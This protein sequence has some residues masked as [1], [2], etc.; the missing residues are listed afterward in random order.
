MWHVC[1][2]NTFDTVS[3]I[4][5]LAR[6][7]NKYMDKLELHAFWDRVSLMEMSALL[8]RNKQEL[9]IEKEKWK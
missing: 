1:E 2:I 3:I 7:F 8:L 4:E 5:K 6:V 9:F